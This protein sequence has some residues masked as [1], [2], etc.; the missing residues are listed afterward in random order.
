MRTFSARAIVPMAVLLLSGLLACSDSDRQL[1][2]E[3]EPWMASFEFN[4]TVGDP[5]GL[6]EVLE[7]SVEVQGLSGGRLP[8]GTPMYLE[9]SNWSFDNGE[10]GITVETVA[11][12]AT[13]LLLVDSSGSAQITA[14]F[15]VGGKR[16]SLETTLMVTVDGNASVVEP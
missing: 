7:V 2:S 8:D 6:P 1:A 13:A 3:P 12:R 10:Q 15:A 16:V 9:T 4:S 5:P 11:S 14:T